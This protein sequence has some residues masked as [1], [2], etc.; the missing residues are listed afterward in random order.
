MA[1]QSLQ[2]RSSTLEKCADTMEMTQ[3]RDLPCS[4]TTGNKRS[5]RW[6]CEQLL[7]NLFRPR[8]VV[9]PTCPHRFTQAQNTYTRSSSDAAD[10]PPDRLLSSIMALVVVVEHRYSFHFS[11]S[12]VAQRK[13]ITPTSLPPSPTIHPGHHPHPKHIQYPRNSNPSHH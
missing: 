11:G 1:S 13:G 3:Q 5:K 10:A 6:C 8:V 12:G 4:Q 2:P 9:A 7:G